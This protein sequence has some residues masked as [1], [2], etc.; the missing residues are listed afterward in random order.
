MTAGPP[1][2]LTKTQSG[3]WNLAAVAGVLS[4]ALAL[5]AVLLCTM[6]GLWAVHGRSITYRGCDELFLGAPPLPWNRNVITGQNASVPMVAGMVSEQLNSAPVRRQLQA[7]IVVGSV[8][9]VVRQEPPA[10]PQ[11]E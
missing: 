7:A 8:A 1:V 9:V 5:A 6:G 3:A 4:G 10:A 11:P 2:L